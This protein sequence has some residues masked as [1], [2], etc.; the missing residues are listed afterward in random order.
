MAEVG[1]DEAGITCLLPE[2][3]GGGV[4]KRVG[5]D[6]LLEVSSLRGAVDDRGQDRRLQPV[7]LEPA[8]DRCLRRRLPGRAQKRKLVCELRCERLAPRL[9]ALAAAN[10]QRGPTALEVEVGP[11]ER[12][13]LGPAQAGLDEGEQDEPVALGESFPASGRVRSGGEHAVELRL[14][15]PVGLLL[16]LRRALELD[17]GIGE[18]VAPAEPL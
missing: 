17:E 9:A 12:D 18:A 5:G 15:Q 14:G 10:E 16:R 4:P 8:E 6:A 13:Q 11:V 3:G 1:G 7:P 2:P